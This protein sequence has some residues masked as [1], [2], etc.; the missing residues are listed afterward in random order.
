MEITSRTQLIELMKH[1]G[2]PLIGVEVGVAEGIFSYELLKLGLEKLY[3]V[4]IWNRVPFI[5]GCASFSQEWHD[6]NYIDALERTKDYIDKRVVLKGFSYQVASEIPDESLGLVYIDGDHTYM[7]V[8]TDI[9]SYYPKLV[10]DGI[11]AFHDFGNPTYGVNRAVQEFTRNEG[12][13]RL[14]ENGD[15]NNLGAYIIKK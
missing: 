11:M 1:N 2:L 8:K 14:I 5:E 9:E 3:M 7:G 6:Q 10:K 13:H 15:I 12:I 4:D